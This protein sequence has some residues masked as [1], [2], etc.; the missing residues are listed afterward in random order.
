MSKKRKLK[1]EGRYNEA[2][3][4]ETGE[5]RKANWTDHSGNASPPMANLVLGLYEFIYVPV[6]KKGIQHGSPFLFN[7][8]IM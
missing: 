7:I 8:K 6:T 4:L 5:L 1:K 2:A 3:G